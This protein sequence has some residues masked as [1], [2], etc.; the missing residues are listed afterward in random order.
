MYDVKDVLHV[1][2]TLHMTAKTTDVTRKTNARPH[3]EPTHER[4]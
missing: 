1:K 4:R 3:G 2:Q